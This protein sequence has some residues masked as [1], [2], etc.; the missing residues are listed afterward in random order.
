MHQSMTEK[1]PTICRGFFYTPTRQVDVQ[2]DGHEAPFVA[3]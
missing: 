2:K 1:A 3:Q